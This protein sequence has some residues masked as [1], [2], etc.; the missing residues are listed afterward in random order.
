MILEPRDERQ[1][2]RRIG[3]DQQLTDRAPTGAHHRSD[4]EERETGL[5]TFGP[6]ERLAHDLVAG[7]HCEDHRTSRVR[8]V[9]CSAGPELSGRECLRAIFTTAEQ[10]EVGGLR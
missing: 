5:Y 2:K 4:V 3:F 1:I 10:V 8:P 7:T 6:R 9:H